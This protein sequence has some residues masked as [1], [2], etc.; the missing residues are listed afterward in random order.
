M[1]RHV[2]RHLT[3]ILVALLCFP[4]S[5]LLKVHGSVWTP[6]GQ[7]AAAPNHAKATDTTPK[8]PTLRQSHSH[9]AKATDSM[10]K[11]LTPRQSHSSYY[12]LQAACGPAT[13]GNN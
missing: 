5:K 7:L 6:A 8:P 4:P 1:T 10:P 12:I 3:E 9:H 13:K 11:P 2:V